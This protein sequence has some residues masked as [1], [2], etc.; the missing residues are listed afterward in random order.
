MGLNGHRGAV[1]LTNAESTDAA[2]IPN[3]SFLS[4]LAR[5]IVET[6]CLIICETRH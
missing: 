6:R 5:A 1:N 4:V 3:G 2:N